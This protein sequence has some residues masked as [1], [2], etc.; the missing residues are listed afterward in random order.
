MGP[1][2]GSGMTMGPGMMGP[3]M[4]MGPQMGSGMGPGMTMG[5]GMMGPGMMMGPHMGHGMMGHGMMGHGMMM[6]R[7]MGHGMRGPGMMG[8]GIGPAW[9][10]GFPGHMGRTL[11]VDDVT[12]ILERRLAWHGN[13]RLKLGAVD[14]KDYRTVTV[15]IMTV[16]DSLVQRLEVDRRTGQIWQTD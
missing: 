5:P 12:K 13:E 1:Q 8:S 11:S 15:E 3:G 14:E 7:Q 10:Y 16:D 4:M 2:M 9:I 6:G